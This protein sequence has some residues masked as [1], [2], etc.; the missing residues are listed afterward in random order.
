MG[1][2]RYQPRVDLRRKVG[3]VLLRGA[4]RHDDDRVARASALISAAFSRAH[5][6]S[7]MRF[8]WSNACTDLALGAS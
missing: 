1:Y 2:L 3:P 7:R 6:I 4:D 8:S 5:S